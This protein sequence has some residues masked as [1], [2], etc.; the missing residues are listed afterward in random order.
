MFFPHIQQT[1]NKNIKVMKKKKTHFIYFNYRI[2][3]NFFS[4]QY[5]SSSLSKIEFFHC[6][7]IIAVVVVVVVDVYSILFVPIVHI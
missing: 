6:F 2:S 1:K 3:K 5:Y 4:F 7:F